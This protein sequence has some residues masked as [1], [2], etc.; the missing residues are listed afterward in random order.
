MYTTSLESSSSVVEKTQ[1]VWTICL[2]THKI[3]K[4]IYAFKKNY[5][6]KDN[7]KWHTKK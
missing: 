1:A 7:K 6:H 2:C 3:L 4:I 5:V